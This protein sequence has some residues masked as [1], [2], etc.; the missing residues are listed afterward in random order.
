MENSCACTG[1]LKAAEQLVLDNLRSCLTGYD[2]CESTPWELNFQSF[3]VQLGPTSA[4]LLVPELHLWALAL[5]QNAGR[6]LSYF[7]RYCRHLCHDEFMALAALSAAQNADD[8]AGLLAL[9]QLQLNAIPSKSDF[10]WRQT[11]RCAECFAT[12]GIELEPIP[13]EAVILAGHIYRAETPP[14]HLLN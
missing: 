7:P 12:A 13:A 4:K 3:L 11:A 9:R 5:R 1:V 6:N 2:L 8:N 10:L 14:P